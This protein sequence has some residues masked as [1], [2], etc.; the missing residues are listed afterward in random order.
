M[1]TKIEKVKLGEVSGRLKCQL[2]HF[3]LNFQD[4]EIFKACWEMIVLELEADLQLL[5]LLEWSNINALIRDNLIRG[6]LIH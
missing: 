6:D 3:S 2:A 4:G 5:V 1:I